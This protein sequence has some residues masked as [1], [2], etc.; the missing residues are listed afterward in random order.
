V[1]RPIAP[2]LL[3]AVLLAGLLAPG[4]GCSSKSD[5]SSSKPAASGNSASGQPANSGGQ[6]AI[7]VSP[8]QQRIA[9]IAVAALALQSA[10][11]KL[12]VPGQVMLNEQRTAHIAPYSDGRVAEVL[13][14]AGDVVRTGTVLAYLHSHSVHETTGALAQDFA[15][16]ERQQAAVVYAQQKRDRYAHLYSI[17]AASLE[18]QQAAEQE[19]LQASTNLANAQAAVTMEREHLGDLLAVPPNSI[20]AANLY[21]HELVP[22]ITPITGTIIARMV[23]PGM[24]LEPGNEVFTVSDLSS[25]WMVAS[26]NQADLAYL[27]TGQQVTAR[28]DAW[29]AQSFAGIVT[30]IGSVLDPATRTVQVRATFQN[31]H[32]QLKPMMFTSMSIDEQA[33]RQA[34]FIHEDALQ[35]VNGVQ[36]VFVASDGTHF[37]PRAVKTLPPVNGQVE[38]TDGLRPGDHIAVAGTFILK[39]DLLK[40]SLGEE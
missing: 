9:G 34:I 26:V 29:P 30:L 28:S 24:V 10:P 4:T 35:E 40:G 38:V 12:T 15:N 20:T 14:N 25:V 18:Q 16:A 36:V 21:A 33:T 2:V 1:T 13:R 17:E 27:H 31:P 37:I 22:V 5:A 6:N 3:L 19:L 7:E 32:G 8:A 39:S 23:T 11:R